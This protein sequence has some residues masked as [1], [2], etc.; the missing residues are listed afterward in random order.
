MRTNVYVNEDLI[1]E[2]RELTQLNRVCK[3]SGELSVSILVL[4]LNS[5]T[6]RAL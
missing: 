4:K 5:P 2:C 1:Q 3:L 6:T